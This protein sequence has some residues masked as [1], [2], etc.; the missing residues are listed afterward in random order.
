MWWR[1][2]IGTEIWHCHS[3]RAPQN[4]SNSLLHVADMVR[5]S[6]GRIRRVIALGIIFE[7]D[8]TQTAWV[9]GSKFDYKILKEMVRSA[10]GILK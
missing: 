9:H 7:I 4:N 6:G 3:G 8:T 2:C 5:E 1:R 10:Q